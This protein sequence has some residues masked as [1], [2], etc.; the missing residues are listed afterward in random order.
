MGRI[1]RTMIVCLSVFAVVSCDKTPAD[2]RPPEQYYTLQYCAGQDW[3]LP[4]GVDHINI[5]ALYGCSGGFSYVEPLVFMRETDG[6]VC[7]QVHEQTCSYIMDVMLE[8]RDTPP[9]TLDLFTSSRSQETATSDIVLHHE[10]TLDRAV[11]AI[12][13]NDAGFRFTITPPSGDGEPELF[14]DLI[15]TARR[16]EQLQWLPRTKPKP[17]DR[18]HL[19]D[20]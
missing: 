1:V 8:V 17:E 13:M 11:R 2:A 6:R 10:I 12:R 15:P 3:S 7:S 4:P 9:P 20:L 16:A 5:R 18:T 14:S 19:M